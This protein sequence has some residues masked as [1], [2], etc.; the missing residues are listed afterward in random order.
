MKIKT[1][2]AI[3]TIIIIAII[4]IVSA[5]F[6]HFL[7]NSASANIEVKGPSF[8][9]D[10][11]NVLLMNKNPE[12][13]SEWNTISRDSW[14]KRQWTMKDEDSLG[15]IDFYKPKIKFVIDLRIED[16]FNYSQGVDLEFGY[17]DTIGRKNKICSVQFISIDSNGTYEIECPT[18]AY[19]YSLRSGK[20]RDVGKFYYA[21]EP[22]TENK[23]EIRT[24]NSYIE[25][26]EKIE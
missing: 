6:V 12:G 7:S 21:F 20:I 19:D 10:V 13:Q 9:T 5:S 2:L 22:L 23:F 14:V 4:G 11:E 18:I 24:K 16:D 1:T 17:F 26:L 15:G 8:Y 3:L 25:I